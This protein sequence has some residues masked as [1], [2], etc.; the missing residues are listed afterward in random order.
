MVWDMMNRRRGPDSGCRATSPRGS[1]SHCPDGF[2]TTGNDGERRTI[3]RVYR[4]ESPG[5]SAL[6]R[7]HRPCTPTRHAFSSCARTSI[8]PPTESRN[9]APRPLETPFF[10]C[11]SYG[12]YSLRFAGIVLVHTSIVLGSFQKLL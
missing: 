4:N 7:T 1:I 3:R 5:I 9:A 10:R 6:C 12:P 2:A 8:N 11:L